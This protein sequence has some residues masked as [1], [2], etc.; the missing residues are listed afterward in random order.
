VT[1]S[2]GLSPLAWLAAL[3]L[4]PFPAQ[5]DEP[6]ELIA[7][8]IQSSLPLYNFEWEDFWP[9]GFTQDGDQGCMSAVAFGD[10]RFVPAEIGGSH[11]EH[12][13]RYDNFGV[14]H[15]AAII[16]TARERAALGDSEEAQRVHGWFVRLGKVRLGS[17]EWELWAVQKGAI[18]GSE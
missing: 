5:A 16:R 14:F 9:R 7:E 2:V 11:A 15:C 18:P 13:E 12:W 10:W 8:R 6:A 1:G 3:L 4:L 17:A